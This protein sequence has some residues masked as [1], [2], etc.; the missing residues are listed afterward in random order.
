MGEEWGA[1]TP[2]LY[3]CDF[4][5]ELAAGGARGR[6]REFA[7]FFDEAEESPIRWTRRPSPA[8]ASTGTS[9]TIRRM[10]LGSPARA[11]CCGCARSEIA[12][13]LGE[14]EASVLRSQV[15]GTHGLQRE[16][17]AS[18]TAGGSTLLANLGPSPTE[19][20]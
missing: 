3:F 17:A 14:G 9:S 2:F 4:H 20:A 15:A 7:A 1:A 11:C 18:P 5:G 13:R 8:R 19:F 16:L 12:P 10:R 6:R